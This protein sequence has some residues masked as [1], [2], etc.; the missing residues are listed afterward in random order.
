MTINFGTQNTE[1]PNKDIFNIQETFKKCYFQI[2]SNEL[3][4]NLY[5][6][7]LNYI[8]YFSNFNSKFSVI[9]KIKDHRPNIKP[10]ESK[11]NKKITTRNWLHYFVWAHKV[12]NKKTGL[13]ENPIRA[14]FN[15][16]HNIYHK[17][18]DA[19]KLLKIIKEKK[20]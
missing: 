12:Q 11:T 16:F 18:V 6:E 19:L 3:I 8:N 7:F 4:I 15:R 1:S 10:S 17:K 2:S 14:E 5:P 20:K 9:E 13:N